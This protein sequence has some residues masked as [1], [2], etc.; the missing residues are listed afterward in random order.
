MYP[1]AVIKQLQADS[2]TVIKV[3]K[4]EDPSAKVGVE[5]TQVRPRRPRRP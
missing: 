4:A 5:G 3:P 2:G 1:G